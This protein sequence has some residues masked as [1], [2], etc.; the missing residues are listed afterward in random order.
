MGFAA[1]SLGRIMRTNTVNRMRRGTSAFFSER[2][3]GRAVGALRG[4]WRLSAGRTRD[5]FFFKKKI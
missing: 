4:V 1:W 2:G 5:T 3:M